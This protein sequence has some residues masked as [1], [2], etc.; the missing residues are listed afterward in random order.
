MKGTPDRSKVLLVEG[1]GDKSV[2]LE[3]L[4]AWEFE[5]FPEIKFCGNDDRVFDDFRIYISNPAEY[6][7]VGIVVDADTNP[8][9]RLQR[10]VQ[11]MEDSGRYKEGRSKFLPKDGLVLDGADGV[12]A[13]LGLWVMP[14]NQS[15]GMLEDLLAPMAKT[16]FPELM[17]AAENALADIERR[18]IQRYTSAHRPKAMIHTYLAWQKD[19]GRTLSCAIAKHYL[20]AKSENARLFMNWIDRLFQR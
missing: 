14:D 12:A 5:V 13:R 20:D 2:I 8:D 3:L 19:P 11:I 18:G 17:A 7:A 6:R 4:T 10:F 15:Y 1:P 9:G 16:A